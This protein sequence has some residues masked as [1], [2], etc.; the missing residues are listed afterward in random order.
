VPDELVDKALRLSLFAPNHK[1][2]HPWVLT[3]VGPVAREKLVELSVELKSSKGQ[4]SDVK[5]RA[6][7][8]DLI[9]P[10][11]LISLAIRRS[12][13]PHRQHE[14]YATLA[15]SVQIASL[16]LWENG[17]ATKWSTGGYSVHEKT[18]SILGLNPEEVSLEGCLL[19]GKA[20][21]MP[22]ASIRPELRSILR[23][24]L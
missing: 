18:Y 19:I 16:Y 10:S 1:L 17:I 13:D 22:R 24:I 11:H 20:E 15:C 6:L 8:Q 3:A 5:K 12:P 4:L 9:R 21:I 23:H 2:S 14:D 7:R